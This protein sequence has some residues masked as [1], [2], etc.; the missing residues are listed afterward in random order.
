MR[1][2][3]GLSSWASLSLR[4]RLVMP[5]TTR[6][7]RRYKRAIRSSK[8]SIRWVLVGPLGIASSVASWPLRRSLDRV[9]VLDRFCDARCMIRAAWVLCL[10]F[11]DA[12]GESGRFVIGMCGKLRRSHSPPVFE[13]RRFLNGKITEAILG[14]G[15]FHSITLLRRSAAARELHSVLSKD[16][17]VIQTRRMPPRTRWRVLPVETA[18][19]PT[20]PNPKSHSRTSA[21]DTADYRTTR[22]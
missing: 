13:F 21:V 5:A 2:L 17:R 19:G 7:D 10:E 4:L 16:V 3:S 8:S 14:V 1:S 6:M 9:P 20:P 11:G 22:A 18:P 15:T 12:L